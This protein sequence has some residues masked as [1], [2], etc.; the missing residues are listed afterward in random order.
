MVNPLADSARACLALMDKSRD[1]MN[2]N[3]LRRRERQKLCEDGI[4][5]LVKALTLDEVRRKIGADTPACTRRWLERVGI[6]RLSSGGYSDIEIDHAID[7][8]PL[9]WSQELAD[10]RRRNYDLSNQVSTLKAEVR[11]LKKR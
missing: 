7:Y 10:L 3:R 2:D 4:L 5:R 9:E 1:R 6:K 8:H 11:S